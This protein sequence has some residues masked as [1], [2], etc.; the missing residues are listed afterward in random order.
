MFGTLALELGADTLG[1][2]ADKLG[3]TSEHKLDNITTAA[4]KYD[5]DESGSAALAWSGIG[6]YNDLVCPYSMLRVVSAIAN[7]G[8][9]NEPSMLGASENKTTLLSSSTASK[10]ASMMNYNVTYKY[11]KSTFSGLDISGKTG[12]AEAA[13]E[14]G[15]LSGIMASEKMISVGRGDRTCRS[16][17]SV[18]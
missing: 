3:L 11:G 13:G 7:G 17:R 12:T 15:R 2:Y 5:K 1:E 8:T 6:Q 10:I 14:D 4:G 9:L 16:T 18:P